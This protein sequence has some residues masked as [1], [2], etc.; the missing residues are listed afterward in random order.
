VP[1]NDVSGIELRDPGQWQK[2]LGL[3]ERP[4]GPAADGWITS[5][6]LYRAVLDRQPYQVRGLVGF[7]ANLLLSHADAARGAEALSSLEFHVQT[8]LY[9]TPT[10]A[11]ADIVLPIASGWEREGLRVGFALDQSACEYVQLRP[12][13]VPPR[14]EARA[15]IDVVF[16]LAVRLGLG[17]RFWQGDVESG[18]AHHLAPSGLTP[19]MLR[20]PRGIARVP[21]ETRY[22]KYREQGFGTPSGKLEIFSTTLQAIGQSPLPEFR[23]PRL[24][25]SSE[26]PLVLTSAKTPIYCHSQHRN[27]PRLR[28]VVPDPVVEMN[29]TTAALH[30]IGQGQ[31][32][33]IS[34]PRGSIRARAHFNSSLADGVVGGQH[35]WW[36]SC[37]G[38]GLPGYDPLGSD[39]ANINLV[40]GD[41]VLDP[42]SGAA[43]HR[44]YP[45]QLR[46]LTDST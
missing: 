10:A 20:K 30:E 39:S 16:D 26:F 4:L 18:L 19:T 21:L 15:D 2:A 38:L 7:G 28:R 40:I 32:V 1:V 24:D 17:N 14:G 13:I 12:A 29:P 9:L 41:E 44:C 23:A 42:I 8:D 5:T 34:T 3:T 35:G 27:L 11:Y 46:G 45:A 43:P 33:S 6:D 22:R 25:L 36:Q 31:W 37:P